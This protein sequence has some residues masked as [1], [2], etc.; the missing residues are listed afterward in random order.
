MSMNFQTQWK[1]VQC[2]QCAKTPESNTY[3]KQIHDKGGMI[4]IY[5]S[6]GRMLGVKSVYDAFAS[7]NESEVTDYDNRTAR[8]HQTA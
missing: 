4:V 7:A 1:T 5:D 3:E 8:D 6:Q 2:A